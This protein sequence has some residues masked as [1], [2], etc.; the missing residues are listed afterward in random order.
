MRD[1]FTPESDVDVLGELEP[2]HVHGLAFFAMQDGLSAI[3]GRNVDLNTPAFLSRY[4][5]DRILAPRP[6]TS[7]SQNEEP[8]R[9]RW[10]VLGSD[11]ADPLG[12]R[13]PPA[14]S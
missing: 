13:E 2:G 12:A 3:L 14:R 7:T 4:F 5:L 6:R 11:P 1:D 8:V 10:T 9:L